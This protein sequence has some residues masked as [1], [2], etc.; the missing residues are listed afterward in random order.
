MKGILTSCVNYKPSKAKVPFCCPVYNHNSTYEQTEVVVYR[1]SSLG[2]CARWPRWI[3]LDHR[4]I[5]LRA[6]FH[7]LHRQRRI[8]LWEMS[9]RGNQSSESKPRT[10][11]V[12]AATHESLYTLSGYQVDTIKWWTAALQSKI[13]LNLTVIPEK[14]RFFFFDHFSPLCNFF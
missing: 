12:R 14:F 8:Q 11:F 10:W 7:T 9:Q 4:V 1:Q 3:I 5:S 6:D 2:I 13:A